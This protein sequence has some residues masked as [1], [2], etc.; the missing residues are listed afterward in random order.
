MAQSFNP[1][2]DKA[3]TLSDGS[4]I[5]HF[6]KDPA[7]FLDRSA[8]YYGAS[9]SGKT[10]AI[11]EELYL[12]KDKIPNVAAF[13]P[14][15]ILNDSYTDTIP[16]NII[17]QQ[18]TRMKVEKI[19]S[20]QERKAQLYS[21]INKIETLRPIFQKIKTIPS[22]V[23]H[24]NKIL[25]SISS[26]DCK[27]KMFLKRI[28]AQ[29]SLTRADK[30]KHSKTAKKQCKNKIMNFYKDAII[31]CRDVLL[32]LNNND[33]E[34][35]IITYIALNPRLLLIF[36]DCIEE[37]N[38][39]SGKSKNKHGEMESSVME[40]IFTKGRWLYITCIIATQDDNKV[41]TTIRKNAYVSIFTEGECAQ[42]FMNNKSN[43]I[44]N[45]KK[46]RAN[47][48]IEAIFSD[49][50]KDNH[51]KLVYYRLGNE[52]NTFTYKIA[53]LYEQFRI[54]SD[55]LWKYCELAERQC[56]DKKRQFLASW[57]SKKEPIEQ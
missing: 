48:A 49:E 42:H 4:T 55:V 57:T 26:V 19:Y 27:L 53:D 50:S 20:D 14:T 2:Y 25:Q 38:A 15:N 3:I 6:P 32:A 44:M 30:E 33:M 51:K 52:H 11:N 45:T 18:L 1:E 28:D 39:I 36:D 22:L 5:G 17:H 37:I 47:L 41:S 56:D 29:K 54:G 8:V 40:K 12:L 35:T 34:K 43:S 7:L 31:S 21:M 46:K 10:T 9:G 24:Y 23:N 16:S 13:V